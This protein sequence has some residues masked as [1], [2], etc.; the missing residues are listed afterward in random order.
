[1]KVSNFLNITLSAILLLAFIGMPV[2]QSYCAMEVCVKECKTKC[3]APDSENNPC[4][5]STEYLQ[6]DSDLSYTEASIKIP[7]LTLFYSACLHFSEK[8]VAMLSNLHSETSYKNPFIT[9]D[10]PVQVRCFRI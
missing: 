9:L 7:D 8:T 5:E 4:K 1:M 6:L 3:C 2:T 10:I